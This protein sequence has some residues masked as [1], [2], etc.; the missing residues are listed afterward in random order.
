MLTR[1]LPE[2]GTVLLAVTSVL[3]IRGLPEVRRLPGSE[4]RPI[5]FALAITVLLAASAPAW[6]GYG[7]TAHMAQHL[8]LFFLVAPLLGTA[9]PGPAILWGLPRVVRRRI[10]RHR[11]RTS[12]L[13]RSPI[14]IW[15]LIALTWWVWHSTFF[16]EAAAR[17]TLAHGVEHASFVIAGFGLWW[18]S[19]RTTRPEASIILAFTSGL[20][21]VLLAAL[22][23]FATTPWYP[24]VPIGPWLDRLADQHVAGAMMW[25]VGGLGYTAAT[26][27]AVIRALALSS[28]AE[29]DT[30]P[31]HRADTNL[32][33]PTGAPT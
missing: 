26:L 25:V 16:Y 13:L 27:G 19:N 18:W 12:E 32:E 28:A 8:V 4:A 15:S 6:D 1:A 21:T 3:Y 11:R 5:R 22:M 9:R 20:H 7:V 31:R 10:G 17:N 2:V 29:P 14:A 24:N 23:T 33:K 30:A